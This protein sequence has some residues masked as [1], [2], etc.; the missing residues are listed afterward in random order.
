MT[1]GGMIWEGGLQYRAV[2][3]QAFRQLV[4]CGSGECCD[5]EA[6]VPMSKI[7]P[8]FMCCASVRSQDV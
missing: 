8:W 5:C 6:R 1:W 3:C 2:R 7:V 4:R